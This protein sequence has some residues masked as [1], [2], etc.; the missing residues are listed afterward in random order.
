MVCDALVLENSCSE[1][2]FHK[3][4]ETDFPESSPYSPDSFSEAAA[5]FD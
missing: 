5:L 1:M 3:N 2:C 4:V